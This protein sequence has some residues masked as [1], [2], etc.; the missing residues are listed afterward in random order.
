MPDRPLLRLPAPAAA[1]SPRG[2]PAFPTN[3]YP[4]AGRQKDKYR[5][6]F[7][8]LREVLS[9]DGDALALRDDPTSLAP[10]RVIVFEIAG[11]VQNLLKAVARIDGLEFMAEAGLSGSEPCTG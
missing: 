3:R 4:S 6:L 10:D 1:E 8:R 2:R 11:T 9:R 7:R 5:P